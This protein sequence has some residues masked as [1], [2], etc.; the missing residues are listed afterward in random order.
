MNKEELKKLAEDLIGTVNKFPENIHLN[1]EELTYFE[2]LTDKCVECGYWFES[3]YIKYS[4]DGPIC[5]E[6]NGDIDE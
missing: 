6:C 3:D 1:L 5:K 2:E 4:E